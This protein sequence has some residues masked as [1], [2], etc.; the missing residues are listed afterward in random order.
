M[1]IYAIK[2][3]DMG[4]T[5]VIEFPN[6]AIA[7]RKFSELCNNKNTDFGKYPSKFEL[8]QIANM[9]DN[10]GE[11]NQDLEKVINGNETIEV[12]S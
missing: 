11:I 3:I 6:K 4:F 10:S 8:W 9:N 5:S 1:K 12:V 7:I 2:D